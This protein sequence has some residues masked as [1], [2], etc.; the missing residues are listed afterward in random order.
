MF[1]LQFDFTA[2]FH[3]QNKE[4]AYR[5]GNLASLL[6]PMLHQQTNS[7]IIFN[8]KYFELKWTIHN[9]EITYNEFH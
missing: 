8:S 4:M 2:V 1:C 6:L 5:V 7:F 9:G 3:R